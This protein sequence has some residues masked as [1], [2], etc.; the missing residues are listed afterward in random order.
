MRGGGES[1]RK[2]QGITGILSAYLV[3]GDEMKRWIPILLCLALAVL[4]VLHP[5]EAGDAVGEALRLCGGTVVPTL[6]P[7]LVLTAILLRLGVDSMLRSL[8]VPI[9]QPL[10]RLRGECA[11]PLIAGLLGGYPT[12]ARAA[13]QL[14]EQGTLTRWETE[15][16]LGFCNNCSPGFLI[17]FVGAGIMGDAEVGIWLYGIHVVSAL[18]SGI[19][20]CRASGKT[21]ILAL[22][23]RM[24][25]A[26][27]T[28]SRA[29]TLSVSDAL[30]SILQI[31]AYVVF[32]RSAA[33]LLSGILPTQ[34]LGAVEMV[35][36]LSAL[37]RSAQGVV[38][39]AGITAWGGV[40]VHCQTMGV[41][42]DLSMGWYLTGKLLQTVISVVL[43]AAVAGWVM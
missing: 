16:L 36:G 10:F 17:G 34:L 31:C 5:G 12:G 37:P 21:E 30:A 4:L 6:F 20:L 14:Y 3:N 29:L 11:V 26:E 41:T 18:L 43:A 2:L 40:S 8:F 7:F 33:A 35:G 28:L 32:F 9:M 24:P 38:A 23:C 39:A 1:C 27:V 25:V 42:G 13:A 19:I 15:R 22:P